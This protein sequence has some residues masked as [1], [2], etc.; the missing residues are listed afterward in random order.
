VPAA[1]L[2]SHGRGSR[3]A[4]HAGPVEQSQIFEQTVKVLQAM[5]VHRPLLLVLEDLHWADEATVG[6]L[7]RL[8]RQ[9]AGSRILVLGTYRSEEVSM[10][11]G[12]EPHL[13]QKMVDELRR[14]LG[15][16]HIDLDAARAREGLALVDALLDI[17]TNRLDDAFRQAL[18]E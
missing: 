14:N 9:V 4:S 3:P 6:L 5:A 17:E 18:Y 7:F 15:E 16:I 2:G 10:G 13:L 8:G 12:G 1:A 11:Q